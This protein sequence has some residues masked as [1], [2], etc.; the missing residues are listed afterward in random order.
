[1]L[2]GIVDALD[3]QRLFLPTSASGPLEF[4]NPDK[5]GCNHDVHGPWKFG[6]VIKHYDLFNRSDSL[7][8][9]EF[10]ADG[11]VNIETMR[12][13]LKE[14]NIQITSMEENLSWRHHGEWWDTLV[15]DKKAF[16]EIDS[17][18]DFINASQYMQAEGLRYALEANRRR[19]FQNSGSIIWQFNEPWP[20]VSCTSL[21]DYYGG[22]KL[23]YDY[24]KLAFKPVHVSLKYDGLKFEPCS[25]FKAGVYLHNDLKAIA[26]TVSYRILD[27]NSKILLSKSMEV[28][29]GENT[30]KL[31]GEFSNSLPK[32]VDLFYV[33]LEF[34]AQGN[35]HKNFYV[36]SA[37]EGYVYKNINEFWDKI[38]DFTESI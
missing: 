37:A 4:L 29:I 5:P 15:R 6:H 35:T 13:F 24:V 11:L 10:G 38:K 3:G 8:H 27:R 33:E 9:S 12:K 18:E 26:G 22:K 16:A 20:N 25:K 17:I 36:F 32:E 30:C 28:E 2:K 34:T 23:A 21:V 7:I 19:K 31:V 1:M 14:E